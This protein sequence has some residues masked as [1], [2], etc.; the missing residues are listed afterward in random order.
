MSPPQV[1][2]FKEQI[3]INLFELA[4]SL[5]VEVDL[6]EVDCAKTRKY[7]LNNTTINKLTF[8]TLDKFMVIILDGFLKAEDGYAKRCDILAAF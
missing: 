1:V 4:T 8:K 7:V 2:E 3:L 6:G 5:S